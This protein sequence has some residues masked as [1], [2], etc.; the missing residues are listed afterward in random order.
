MKVYIVQTKAFYQI[1]GTEYQAA[2][3]L[4]QIRVLSSKKKAYSEMK[5]WEKYY[6]RLGYNR[7]DKYNCLFPMEHFE[8]VRT[9]YRIV[10]YLVESEVE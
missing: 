1:D 7:K 9:N 3:A 10:I 5:A 8:M 2:D 6:G 4:E